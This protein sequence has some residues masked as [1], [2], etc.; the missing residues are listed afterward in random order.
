M[1]ED[2]AEHVA[3]VATEA[4]TNLLKHASRGQILLQTTTE[5]CEDTPLLEL[6][7]V[8]QGPGMENLDQCLRD[9]YSTGSSPGQGLG[10]IQRM[11]RESDFYTV[12]GKGTVVLARWWRSDHSLETPP[13][14]LE[15]RR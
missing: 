11:S 10:A 12:P 15:T 9:G 4:C 6:L 3:I 7:A 8:D 1:D 5:G 14:R 13:R 2:G